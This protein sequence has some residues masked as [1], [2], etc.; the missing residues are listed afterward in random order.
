MVYSEIM[1]KCIFIMYVQR[2]GGPQSEQ[3]PDLQTIL[4]TYNTYMVGHTPKKSVRAPEFLIYELVDAVRLK[5][6]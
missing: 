1:Q 6:S 5:E 4:R 2:R 3:C